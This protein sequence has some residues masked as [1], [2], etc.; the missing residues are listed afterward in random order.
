MSN[1]IKLKDFNVHYMI[2]N[3]GDIKLQI[4]KKNG[5]INVTNLCKIGGKLFADY[6]KNKYSKELM[7]CLSKN[8]GIKTD[9]LTIFINNGNEFKGTFAHPDLVIHI[10][11]W[12]SPKFCIMVNEI[13]KLWR[14]L[15]IKNENDYWYNMSESLKFSYKNEKIEEDIRNNLSKNLNGKTEVKCDSGYIDIVT[16]E[17]IIEVKH[18]DNWKHALGQVLSYHVDKNFKKLKQR[19][20][21]FSNNKIELE[22]INKITNI[23]QNYSCLV[24]FEII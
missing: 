19:I 7:N 13:I 11:M 4:M 22:T 18:I 21:L 6:N 16:D 1:N 14:N 20:H 15:S 5:Y 3:Y 12:I 8:L 10:A 17:E 23:C 24:S 9:E 2:I